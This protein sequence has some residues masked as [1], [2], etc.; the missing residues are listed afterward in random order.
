[1]IEP[2]SDEDYI[3]NVNEIE[4]KALAIP[5]VVGVSPHINRGVILTDKYGTKAPTQVK[6]IDPEKEATASSLHK[7]I[8]SGRYLS[9]NLVGDILIGADITKKYRMQEAFPAVDVDAG[10]KIM[11]TF[12]NGVT[13]QLKVRGIYS[14]NFVAT[15]FY[16]FIT[17]EEAKQVF[18]FT[19]EEMNIATE[20]MIKTKERGI[21]SEVIYK[22]KQFGISGRI[23]SWQEKLGILSQF[24]DSMLIVSK[25]TG[26]IGIIIAFATIYIMI[27]INVLHKRTQIGIMKAMGINKETILT[28]Y[29]IQSFFYG[30]LGGTFGF[31]LTKFI[32]GYFTIN[33]I[34]MPIGAVIP[35]VESSNYIFS[36]SILLVSSLVAGYF[37]A[38]GVIKESILEAIFR[39]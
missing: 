23:W 16:V 4:K 13:K 15:D 30:V 22:L 18:N 9:K 8:L 27:Y 32:I 26:L 33:P 38:Q 28:S 10:E 14:Q 21:E 12:D 6:I 3:Q 31:I 19:D 36:F 5:G 25:I 17:K 24:T 37:P 1:L 39:G 29:V 11:V 7:N 35:M 20:I 34:I 2:K